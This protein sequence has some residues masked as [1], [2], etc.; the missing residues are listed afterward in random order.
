MIS[1]S[2][3]P[4]PVRAAC[5]PRGRFAFGLT[6]RTIWLLVAGLALALPG[7]FFARL[8]YGMLIWDALVLVAA[9]CWIGSRLALRRRNHRGALVE[10]R[11][12]S[13]QPNRNRN[14]RRTERRNN[15]WIAASSTICRKR[16]WPCRLHGV[17]A[18]IRACGPLCATPSIRAQRG[19]VTTGSVYLR[20]RSLLGLIDKW[21]MAPLQQTVR[22]Y[23]ALRQGEDQE[24]FLARGR[25]I[26]L[27]LRQVARARA[28]P[29]LREPPRVSRRRRPARHLLDGHGAT[30]SN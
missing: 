20:Y 26:D 11:A 23:P 6:P 7:F 4:E 28:G 25:Q 1:A 29:R 8:G 16:W 13:F 14:R 22:V 5:Q 2:L 24:I 19:D 10:Q 9:C 27:E 18:S 15:I 17:C 3:H 30:R 12:L 21:A